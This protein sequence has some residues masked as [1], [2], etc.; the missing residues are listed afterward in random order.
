MSITNQPKDY[1]VLFLDMN[2][3]FAS[4]EQQVQP[5]LRGVPLGV[6]PYTGDT[7]CIIA[8]SREAK[9]LGISISRIGEAKKIY[10]QIKIIEARPAL[11]MI[12]H[13]EICKVIESFTPYFE[14]LSIDEFAIRLTPQDQNYFSSI[15]LADELKRAILARVG[16]WLTCSIGIGPSVFLAKVAGERHKPNGLT[17]VALKDLEDFYSKLRLTD[18]VGIN[19]RMEIRLKNFGIDSPLTFYKT[20]MGDLIQMLKHGGRLWYFRLR[21]HEVDDYII[22]NKT[23]GHSHVLP[24]EFRTKEGALQVLRRL[25][26]KAG[27]RIRKE[28]YSAGG[29]AI[30]INFVDRQGFQQSRKFASFSDNDSFLKN[31]Y[32]IL[33]DCPWRSRPILVSVSA[34]NLVR[35]DGIQ[36]SIFADI[37]K[38]RRISEALDQVNDDYGADTIYPASTFQSRE[39]APDRIPFGKPRYEILH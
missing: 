8:A 4:V 23:I 38:S 2:S 25:I 11:Y 20:S 17:T 33:K 36:I 21:G 35:R 7:G 24:P 37:E 27:Y 26:F 19:W 1:Q 30:S 14:A 13:K 12:Y 29:V 32:E 5:A 22:K 16:D 28:N 39:T 10:P 18:L 15:K 9:A 6:A 31:A 34:F 3:F